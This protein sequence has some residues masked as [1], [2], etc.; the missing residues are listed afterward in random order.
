VVRTGTTD[1]TYY[2]WLPSGILLESVDAS[3][4]ARRFYHFDESGSANYLTDDTGTVTD[5]YSVTPYGELVAHTGTSTNPFTFQGA[6]GVMQEAPTSLYY[7]RARFY[8][9]GSARFLSRDPKPSPDPRAISPYQFCYGD[10]VQGSD[11]SGADN[12]DSAV[13]TPQGCFVWRR[14]SDN[15]LLKASTAKAFEKINDMVQSGKLEDK[16]GI[17]K[18]RY[19][20][21]KVP[22]PDPT[23]NPPPPGGT[24]VTPAPPPVPKTGEPIPTPTNFYG[25]SVAISG[26]AP[27]GPTSTGCWVGP[28][29]KKGSA[30]D[31]FND[32]GTSSKPQSGYHYEDPCKH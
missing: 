30:V 7:M 23:K 9:S 10:P 15:T 19:R 31:A 5:S 22:C 29:G 6:Y 13:V 1:Q 32:W 25:P 8:D 26:T 14:L 4:G 2:I 24:Y 11:P 20:R 21:E 17:L 27:T 3:S 18:K 16:N 12:A 28:D